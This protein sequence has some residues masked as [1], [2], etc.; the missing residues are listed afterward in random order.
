MSAIAYRRLVTAAWARIGEIDRAERIK[1]LH[2]QD[3]DRPE[4]RVGDFNASA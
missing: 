3:G 1:A 4:Q 2:V